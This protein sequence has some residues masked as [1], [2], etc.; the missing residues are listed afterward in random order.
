VL[1]NIPGTYPPEDTGSS[2]LA[3]AKALKQ[4]GYINKFKHCFNTNGLL[5]ALQKQPVII[6]MPWYE[7]MF[8][9]DSDGVVHVGGDE[10]GGHEIECVGWDP[11]TLRFKFYNSW[12]A[13]W[14]AAGAFYLGLDDWNTLR[15]Q[16]A[17][18][19]VPLPK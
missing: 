19:V 1:D 6:G 13:E 11:G 18:V 8:K 16:G 14:G 10:A 7:G 2:G 9:P 4:L 3:I 17:D 12:G 5:Q 15:S